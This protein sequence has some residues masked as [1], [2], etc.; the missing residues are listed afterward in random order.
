MSQGHPTPHEHV[1][2]NTGYHHVQVFLFE[3]LENVMVTVFT[4]EGHA[5][6]L[7]GKS[8]NM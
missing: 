7:T 2:L 3:E 6:I 4:K 8:E 1:Q 5:I